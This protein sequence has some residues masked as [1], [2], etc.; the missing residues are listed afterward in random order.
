[1]DIGRLRR[2]RLHSHTSQHN[3]FLGYHSNS[4]GTSSSSSNNGNASSGNNGNGSS[5]DTNGHGVRRHASVPLNGNPWE[6]TGM[7]PPKTERGGEGLLPPPESEDPPPPPPPPLPHR[8]PPPPAGTELPPGT[9]I[10]PY[11]ESMGMD[12]DVSRDSVFAAAQPIVSDTASSSSWSPSDSTGSNGHGHSCTYACAR[13]GH[14]YKFKT[15]IKRRFTATMEQAQPGPPRWG[16]DPP[17]S[18][19]ST[20]SH[21]G[22]SGRQDFVVYRPQRPASPTGSRIAIFALHPKG[23]YYVPL[24]LDE[25]LVSSKLASFSDSNPILHPISISVNFCG[26]VAA[27]QVPTWTVDLASVFVP[28]AGSGPEPPMDTEPKAEDLSVS[29]RPDSGAE[30]C[31]YRPYQRVVA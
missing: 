15:N 18:G 23:S 22:G 26:A 7:S 27:G 14:C 9:P 3:L 11:K 24:T 4:G 10:H 20:S 29:E 5:S 21:R 2:S 19:Y 28:K 16:Y 1:M 8:P 17:S 6:D 30:S 13:Q 31:Q 25:R 12:A